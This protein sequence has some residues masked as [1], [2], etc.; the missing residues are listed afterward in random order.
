[1]FIGKFM[2]SDNL[3]RIKMRALSTVAITVISLM[4]LSGC[5]KPSSNN[6]VGEVDSPSSIEEHLPGEETKPDTQEAPYFIIDGKDVVPT[7]EEKV[8]EVPMVPTH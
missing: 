2:T 1:M 4:L 5:D 3:E 7:Y 8:Y 6:N